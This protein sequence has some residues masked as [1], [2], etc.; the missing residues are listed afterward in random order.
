MKQ[1]NRARL[2]LETG[3]VD[4]FPF[5]NDGLTPQQKAKHIHDMNKF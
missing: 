3:K 5:H 2:D 4:I 1:L